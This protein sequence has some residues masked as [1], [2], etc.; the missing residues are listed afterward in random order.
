MNTTAS[1]K[2]FETGQEL[3]SDPHFME[4]QNNVSFNLLG[5]KE[6]MNSLLNLNFTINKMPLA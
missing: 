4:A 1:K 6:K 5:T 3:E 2:I